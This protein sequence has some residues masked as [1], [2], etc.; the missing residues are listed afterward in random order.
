M[1]SEE[2]LPKT[3]RRYLQGYCDEMALALHRLTGRPLGL[4]YAEL[5]DRD[6]ELE[7]QPCHAVVLLDAEAGRYLDI[8]GETCG[9]DAQQTLLPPAAGEFRRLVLQEASEEQVRSAFTTEEIAE[10][11]IAE[12]AAVARE[13]LASLGLAHYL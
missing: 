13:R 3:L 7:L 5:V 4:I 8:C 2:G 6:G 9:L 10:S 1:Q 11:A 12:A